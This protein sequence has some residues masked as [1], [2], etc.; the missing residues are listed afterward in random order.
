MMRRGLLSVLFTLLTGSAWVVWR[1]RGRKN[2]PVLVVPD[3]EASETPRQTPPAPP[4]RLHP[5][6]RIQPSPPSQPRAARWLVFLGVIALTLVI[7]TGEAGPTRTA[8]FIGFILLSALIGLSTREGGLPAL[9][10]QMRRH[11][12]M[13]KARALANHAQIGAQAAGAAVVFMALSAYLFRPS[14]DSNRPLDWATLSALAGLLCLGVALALRGQVLPALPLP[15]FPAGVPAFKVR[16]R[17]LSAGIFLLFLFSE[18]SGQLFSQQTFKDGCYFT[19]QEGALRDVCVGLFSSR[20]MPIDIQFALLCASVFLVM[21]GVAGVDWLKGWWRKLLTVEALALTG[22]LVVAF[23][24]RFW[25]LGTTIRTLVDEVHFSSGIVH[26]W[27][28]DDIGMMTPMTGL[29]PFPWIYPYWQKHL[30]AIFGNTLVGFRVASAIIGTLNI[31]ALYWLAK[32]LFDRK[33]AALGA[34]MLTCFPPHVHFSR[35]AILQIADP[36]F[37]TLGFALLARA[38]TAPQDNQR[39]VHYALGGICIAFS[40]YFYE[41]GRLLFPPL[42]LVWLSGLL[43]LYRD[44]LAAQWRGLLLALA[45]FGLFTIPVYYPLLALRYPLTGRLNASGLDN[46]YWSNVLSGQSSLFNLDSYLD[47]LRAPFLFYVSN[48]EMGSVY[49]GG[50]EPLVISAA[51]PVFLLGAAFALWRWRTPGALLLFLWM[52]ASSF[53]NSLLVGSAVASRYLV[54]FPP[55]ALLLALGIRFTL[56]LL[57][58]KASARAA[59]TVGVTVLLCGAQVWYYFGPHLQ[60]YQS[61]A[62]PRRDIQDAVLRSVDFPVNTRIHII[63]DPLDDRFYGNEMLGFF[64]PGLLLDVVRPQ[65]ITEE[66]ILALT[67]GVDHAFYFAPTDVD[68]LRFLQKYLYLEG[69]QLSPYPMPPRKQ[70]V[71]YYAP[72]LFNPRTI[73]RGVPEAHDPP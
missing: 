45:T 21:W 27:Y 39:R 22:L 54:V 44:R 36:L 16:W 13:L 67:W 23:L 71:L 4:A 33:T 3:R 51:V 65:D 47:H 40:Q 68:L 30:V 46:T 70:Y 73:G 61:Q 42:A 1:A 58:L 72:H 55:M 14:S 57:P 8:A 18:V 10:G 69:P 49:Y 17:P 41:A 37:A 35:V 53:G 52:M 62:R 43:Y 34:V 59:A 7:F 6:V 28:R 60:A 38:L 48:P 5:V 50:T 11:G 12:Q 63:S 26:L 19:F 56:P 24:L 2:A 20:Y 66:Y 64:A 15:A 29:S 9:W 32:T 31:A 25:E